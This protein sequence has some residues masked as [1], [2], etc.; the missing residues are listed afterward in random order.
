[1]KVYLVYTTQYP[2]Y[3]HFQLVSILFIPSRFLLTLRRSDH[4]HG[5][6]NR[7]ARPSYLYMHI[8]NI[9]LASS[10]NRHWWRM[11]DDDGEIAGTKY[12]T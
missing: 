9:I 11:H 6:L 7:E 4:G 10:R 3:I 2:I 1:M 5:L 8:I 12:Q